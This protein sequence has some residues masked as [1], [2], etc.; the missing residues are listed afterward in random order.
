M[1]GLGPLK[2]P[3]PFDDLSRLSPLHS[4]QKPLPSPE[5][6]QLLEFRPLPASLPLAPPQGAGEAAPGAGASLFLA[7][8]QRHMASSTAGTPT[9][10]AQSPVAVRPQWRPL[11]EARAAP[12]PAAPAG[13][14]QPQ[15]LLAP[16]Q[17]LLHILGAL[18]QSPEQLSLQHAAPLAAAQPPAQQL[19]RQAQ[20]QA[21]AEAP[22]PAVPQQQPAATPV[23]PA[24]A[25]A[26]SPGPPAADVVSVLASLQSLLRAHPGQAASQ[27]EL[28]TPA[29]PQPPPAPARRPPTKSRSG[30]RS[31]SRAG[32][33]ALQGKGSGGGSGP[34]GAAAGGTDESRPARS[35][36]CRRR[37]RDSSPTAGN[38][39]GPA[40]PH[41]L[42]GATITT[43]HA[44]PERRGSGPGAG[45]LGS[46]RG[47][48]L[49]PTAFTTSAVPSGGPVRIVAAEPPAAAVAVAPAG[50]QRTADDRAGS[51]GCGAAALGAGGGV[52][53][54]FV[55]GQGRRPFSYVLGGILCFESPGELLCF[56][57]PLQSKGLGF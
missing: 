55:A 35:G 57:A 18:Q 41:L 48:S 33:G 7:A 3:R 40:A 28:S 31:G 49:A 54:L 45:L 10:A 56:L 38:A 22:A 14:A 44:S 27:H 25:G 37:A 29:Q 32:A 23:Q 19:Q 43:G 21:Q 17:P 1:Q 52:P 20:Q 47:L 46:P 26:P 39:G 24:P 5:Q 36:S 8:L 6:A 42:G 50:H 53:P 34:Q 15:S 13:P 4:V 16:L 2:I 11:V 51:R 9:E 30:R 12:P